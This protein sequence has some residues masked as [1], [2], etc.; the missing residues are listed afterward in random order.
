MQIKDDLYIM[1]TCII[2]QEMYTLVMGFVIGL[3]THILPV[4][5]LTN[6]IRILIGKNCP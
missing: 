1:A 5:T 3:I 2:K 4:E 6:R